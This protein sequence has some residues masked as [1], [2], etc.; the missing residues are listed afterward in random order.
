ML[1]IG[2]S[3]IKHYFPDF[4]REPKDIDFAV[5]KKDG[6]RQPSDSLKKVEYLENPIILKYQKEGYCNPDLLLTL[7][8]S[9]MFWDNMWDKHMFDIQFLFKKGCRYNLNILNELR[10]LWDEVLPKVRRS[11]LEQTKEDFFTNAVNEDVDQHDIL[12]TY[13]NPIP[14]FTL[15]L[16]DGS[17]VELDENKWDE[18]SFENKLEVVREETY[19][20]A[21]ERYKDIDYRLAFKIQLKQNIQKHFPQYI[22]LFAIENYIQL[23]RPKIKYR[24]I[25][26]TKLKENE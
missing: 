16:K 18:M 9:H 15:L 23:E 2:S 6:L 1:R 4:N 19:V 26:N 7:K 11:K 21:W 3:A 5:Y 17:E 24:E 8:L 25:I 20:M 10:E 14:M 13:I 12:H 22:A